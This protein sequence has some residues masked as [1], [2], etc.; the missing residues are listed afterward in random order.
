M[1]HLI[2][3]GGLAQPLVKTGKLQIQQLAE[4]QLH[5]V[6]TPQRRH[7]SQVET[8]LNLEILRTKGLPSIKS[9]QRGIRTDLSGS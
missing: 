4:S 3:R 8:G 2:L 7:L 9:Y 6:N 1:G 5:G